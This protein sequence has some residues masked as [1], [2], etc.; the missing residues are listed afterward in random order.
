[1]ARFPDP[2]HAHIPGETPR[3]PDGTFDALCQ[4][5]SPEQPCG[6]VF[7]SPAWRA[8]LQFYETGYFWEAHELWEAVWMA[9]P[10]GSQEKR[11]VQ[12]MIQLAN[13]C[14]KLR[15]QRP[16]AVL[17]LCQICQQHLND[18]PSAIWTTAGLEEAEIRN[19]ITGLLQ[20]T[21]ATL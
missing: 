15:M 1:M 12:G 16:G 10:Q 11:F 7:A 4:T 21:Q 9:L 20:T 17:R 3:H 6:A 5:V 13:A 19:R 18:L 2:P 14:L 8:G